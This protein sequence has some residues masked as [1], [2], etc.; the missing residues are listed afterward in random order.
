MI[1]KLNPQF[2]VRN[3]DNCS[4][5]IKRNGT[6]SSS[7]GKD[8]PTVTVI[9]PAIGYILDKIGQ[10]NY[11][12]SIER[13]SIEL[14]ISANLLDVFLQKL[15][16]DTPKQ[17]TIDGHNIIF[18]QHLLIQLEFPS[19]KTNLHSKNFTSS[20]LYFE[21]PHTP[22][23][24]NFMITTKC[25]TNCCYCYAKRNF[26]YELTT[27]EIIKFIEDC[28]TNKI[29]NLNLTGGDIFARKDWKTILTIAKKFD[30]NPFIST[31][32]PLSKQEIYF[33]NSIGI[34][35][36][37]FSLDSCEAS[38][39]HSIIG[40]QTNYIEDVKKMFGYCQICNIKLCIRTVLCNKNA[41]VSIISNLYR[42]INQYNNIKEWVL[43]PAFYSQYKPL[44]QQYAV[45]NDNLIKIRNY[46]KSLDTYFSVYLSKMTSCGYK[47]KLYPTVDEYVSYNQ[48]C[49][50]NSYSMSVLAS[51]EC[52]ICE[53]LYDNKEYL[54]GNIRN[55]SLSEIWNS[56]KALAL[57]APIQE[58]ISMKSPCHSC[59]VFTKCKKSIAKRVCYVDIAK[60]H[61]N[62][63][64]DFP[65]PRC[66]M[67][68]K[69]NVIL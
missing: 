60:V 45:S 21:R 44:Y 20:K 43:T 57:Y 27:E 51:G 9:P 26:K 59:S 16:T 23:S 30:Y 33:L 62:N 29:V 47:L 67:A 53:M 68:E 19:N 65:D 49:H 46:I 56:S 8:I 17:M 28:Y 31:K 41:E 25:T 61:E 42:F 24:V 4:F 11:K 18:P 54:I 34:N 10:M 12:A 66:P 37:Q 50:A 55:Q 22:I 2:I 58:N 52:T 15:S 1:L 69:V 35:E 3:E 63:S 48:Q 13:L 7:F 36:I 5:L 64:F 38:I 32:T 6:I 14:N 39:L 40:A